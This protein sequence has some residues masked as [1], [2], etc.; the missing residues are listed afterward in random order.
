MAILR[1]HL[2]TTA[3][4]VVDLQEKLL[5][6]IH[7]SERILDRSTKLIQACRL[8]R[9][10][11]L[12][13]E[14]YP[15]GLGKTVAA[16]EESLVAVTVRA[17]EGTAG[18]RAEKL[19]FSAC[20]EPVR[21]FL[22]EHGI[23]SVIVCGIEAHVCV[24]QTCLDLLEAGLVVAIALDAIGS[25]KEID[26]DAAVQRMVQAGAVPVTVEAALFEM[27]EQAG[28]EPFKTILPIIK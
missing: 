21:S 28:T 9:I 1:L 11:T 4:L 8:L 5:G 16:V 12:V 19:R 7:N 6:H 20:V 14:Q 3:L 25:R 15:K 22:S 26:R 27:V 24:L 23:R 13:T 18:L 17:A 10:P 2:Q